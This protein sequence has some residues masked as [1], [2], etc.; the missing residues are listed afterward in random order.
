MLVSGWRVLTETSEEWSAQWHGKL[1]TAVSYAVAIIIFAGPGIPRATADILIGAGAV[2]MA[3]SLLMYIDEFR[4]LLGR[5]K[6][7]NRRKVAERVR[8]ENPVP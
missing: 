4:V 7:P 8:G 1:N 6:R 2:C 5:V 3:M